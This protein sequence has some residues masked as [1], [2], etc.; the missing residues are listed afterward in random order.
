V[1]LDSTKALHPMAVVA[2][3]ERE[4]PRNIEEARGY[5]LSRRQRPGGIRR[6]RGDLRAGCGRL[7]NRADPV[8]RWHRHNSS[9][10]RRTRQKAMRRSHGRA[11]RLIRHIRRTAHRG[12]P[13]R[14]SDRRAPCCSTPVRGA[15]RLLMLRRHAAD[16]LS[17]F[18]RPKSRSR[19]TQRSRR[20]RR[21]CPGDRCAS[22][23][24]LRPEPER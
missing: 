21:T 12:D 17:T 3:H 8:A 22:S 13:A 16:W 9:K 19:Q 14:R 11:S 20:K 6:G 5:V 1:A 15:S 23:L 10:G 7:T 18:P 2:G 24:P 4:D